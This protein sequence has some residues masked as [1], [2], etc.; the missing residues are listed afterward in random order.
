M[1]RVRAWAGGRPPGRRRGARRD[2]GR[3]PSSRC[4]AT[5]ISR[6]RRG[7]APSIPPRSTTRPASRRP[8]WSSDPW[9][10]AW[11][12]PS[13]A[14]RSSPRRRSSAPARTGGR[15]ARR[16][17][18]PSRAAPSSRIS[19]AHPRRGFVVHVEHGIGRYLGLVLQIRGD[20]HGRSPDRRVRRRRQALPPRLPP[21]PGAEVLRGRGR[22]QAR[23]AQAGRPV[24]APRPRVAREPPPDGRRALLRLY[25]ERK[26]AV[27]VAVPPMDDEYRAFADDKFPFDETPDQ[28]R[29]IAEVDA[30]LEGAAA[31]WTGW[32]AA[33]W[34]SSARPR[35]PSA[36]PSAWPRRAG[37]WPCSAPPTV[38]AAAGTSSTSRPGWRAVRHRGAGPCPASRPRPSRT[39]WGRR[40]RDGSVDI[41]IGTHRLLSKDIHFKQLGLLVVDE[42]QRFGVAH[43]ERLKQLKTNLDVLYPHGHAHPSHPTGDGRHRPPRH[44]DHHHAPPPTGAPSARW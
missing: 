40:L 21:E 28:A 14:W 25:A 39:R 22:A 13:K 27:G 26:A 29:A 1:R 34:A 18:P 23:P 41:V 20:L 7:S 3:A 6:S 38:L 24:P 12:P 11:W 31:R 17:S 5:A 36:P 19:A 8:W 9:R 33:T 15:R 35:W 43:K 37:R 44:V 10:A 2:P 42:E 30:D 32:C 16:A 4:S